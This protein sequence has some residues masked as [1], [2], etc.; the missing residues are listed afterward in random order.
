MSNGVIIPRHKHLLGHDYPEL[1]DV[2]K[3]IVAQLR[4][5]TGFWRSC[6][7]CHELDE[8]VPTGQFSYLF[9]CNL[10]LGCRE[11]GGIGAVWDTTDYAAM[12]EWLSKSDEP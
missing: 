4:E 1:A 10:G 9:K 7:G 6:S 5:D 2:A 11:C 12:G 3:S 8:G